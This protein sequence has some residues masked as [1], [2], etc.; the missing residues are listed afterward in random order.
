MA[1]WRIG[2]MAISRNDEKDAH[3]IISSSPHLLLAL[4][5]FF[6]NLLHAVSR[7]PQ[8]GLIIVSA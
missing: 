4:S 1:M 5:F 3:F 6:F 2:E 7:I 8:A